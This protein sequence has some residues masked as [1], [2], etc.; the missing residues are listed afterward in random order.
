MAP[1]TFRYYD[2]DSGKEKVVEHGL[3][4]IC[5]GCTKERLREALTDIIKTHHAFAPTS[6][7]RSTNRK[8]SA[9]DSIFSFWPL[10][11]IIYLRC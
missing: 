2:V 5:G 9:D 3:S 1:S 6:I 4:C 7:R 8:L 10:A 11:G